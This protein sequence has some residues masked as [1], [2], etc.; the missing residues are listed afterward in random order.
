[1]PPAV[2]FLLGLL[3]DL[4]GLGPPGV[5]ALVLLIAHGIAFRWRHAL[6]RQGF[7]VVW[8]AFVAI[9]AGA[10]ALD[11]SLTSLLRLRLLPPLPALFEWALA[12]G[13]YPALAIGL[14]WAHRTVAA[15]ERV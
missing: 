7:A 15:P 1:M 5:D 14:T 6:S 10:A 4:L 11:W 9:A 12:A 13:F 3:A 8:L 2:V